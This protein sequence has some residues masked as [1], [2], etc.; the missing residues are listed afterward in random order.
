MSATSPQPSL[1]FTNGG[2]GDCPSGDG[3]LPDQG[4]GRSDAGQAVGVGILV[5]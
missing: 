3:L 4:L 5:G 2:E 1:P